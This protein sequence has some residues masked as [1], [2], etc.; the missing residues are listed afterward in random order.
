MIMVLLKG[1]DL[2]GTNKVLLPLNEHREPSFLFPDLS[3]Y[4]INVQWGKFN[5]T[6]SAISHPL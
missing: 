6:L 5:K 2:Y 4:Y 1:H 3:S